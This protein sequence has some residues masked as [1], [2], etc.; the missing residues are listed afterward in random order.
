[1]SQPS[2]PA[3]RAGAWGAL[4]G[5]VGGLCCAGPSAAVLL[6]L[7]SSSVLAGLVFERSLTLAAGGVLLVIGL[8]LVLRPAR[9]CSLRDARRWRG[10]A[11]MLAAFALS[12]ALIGYLLPSI[13]A[14]EIET[15][16]VPPPPAV[17]TGALLRRATLLIDKMTCPPCAAHVR[18]AL[19]RNP[20]VRA[21]FAEA[22]DEQVTIDYDPAR[23]SARQL[24]IHFPL[25]YGATLV[26]DSALP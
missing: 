8:A 22:G 24:A 14:R 20:A 6:G 9:D 10:P 25:S 3:T 13:A 5:L 21:F 16:V 4:A 12:Y 19:K 11:L 15:V 26:S 23:T 17:A 1:M 7:G 2:T 18:N